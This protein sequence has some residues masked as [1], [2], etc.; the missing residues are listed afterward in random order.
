[1]PNL[2]QAATREERDTEV[3]RRLRTTRRLRTRRSVLALK[4][5]APQPHP[6]L[7]PIPGRSSDAPHGKDRGDS[8]AAI[9]PS[10]PGSQQQLPDFEREVQ[11]PAPAQTRELT[12]LG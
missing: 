1:M 9:Q 4:G 3:G 6:R 2:S 12:S 10:A 11:Q 8:A 5:S 7:T